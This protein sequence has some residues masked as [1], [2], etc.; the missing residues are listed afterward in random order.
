MVVSIL[1]SGKMVNDMARVNN[2]GPMVESLMV[3]GKKTLLMEMV[4]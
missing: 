2:S 1:D 3:I 4:D